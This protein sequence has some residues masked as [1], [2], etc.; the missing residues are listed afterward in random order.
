VLLVLFKVICA[1]ALLKEKK[2][3]ILL[4]RIKFIR[5]KFTLCSLKGF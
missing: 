2:E 3:K 1:K 5:V 4:T